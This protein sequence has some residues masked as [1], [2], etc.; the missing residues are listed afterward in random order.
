MS[1]KEISQKCGFLDKMRYGN[2][3][4][5]DRGFNISEDLHVALCGG[6]LWTPAF[7]REKS[8][9]SESE[10]E[11]TRQL[12]RVRIYVERVICQMRKK[13]K[14]LQNTLPVSLIKCP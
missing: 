3:I 8:Q 4:M 14:I 12:A 7:T 11:M 13:F 5:V 1:D 2:K 6:R 10:V 9:L